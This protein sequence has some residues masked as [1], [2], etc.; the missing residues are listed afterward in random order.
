M[1]R[2]KQ[3]EETERASEALTYGRSVGT[4]RPGV[5][6]TQ[7]NVLRAL[8]GKA[9]DKQEQMGNV[10]REMKTLHKNKKETPEIKTSGTETKNALEGLWTGHSQKTLFELEDMTT[11]VPKLK[12][13]EKKD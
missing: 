4:V 5:F 1:R 9:D 12:S 6:K 13:K 2:D 3:C 10:R 8:M 11:E 7:I